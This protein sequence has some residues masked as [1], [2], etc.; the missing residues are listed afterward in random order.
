[1]ILAEWSAVPGL[2]SGVEMNI[3]DQGR[4]YAIQPVQGYFDVGM[5]GDGRQVLMGL[6]CPDLVAVFFDPAGDLLGV[7]RRQMDFLQCGGV[8]VDGKPIEGAVGD[9]NIYDRRIPPRLL[10]WQDEVD[11]RPATIRVKRFFIPELGIEIEDYPE[12]FGEILDDPNSSDEEKADVRDSMETWDADGQFVL[13]WGNDYWLDDTG[14][15]VS[16]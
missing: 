9:Y 3:R 10:A 2:E 1:M 14:E 11:F 13:Y 7:E 12:H 15:V 16:S 6:S 8:L 4:L 5:T